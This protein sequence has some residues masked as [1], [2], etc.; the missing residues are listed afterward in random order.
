MQLKIGLLTTQQTNIGDDLIRRGLI[1]V[2]DNCNNGNEYFPVN[3]HWPMHAYPS[4]HPL[5]I[6]SRLSPLPKSLA[7]KLHRLAY[8]RFSPSSSVFASCD[9]ILQCGTPVYHRNCHNDEWADPIWRHIFVPLSER[10]PIINLAAGACFP[11]ADQPES[12]SGAPSESYV[13]TITEC[14]NVTTVRDQLA[15][16]LVGS[17]TKSAP[18]VVPC[19]AFLHDYGNDNRESQGTV[20]INYMPSAGHFNWGKVVDSEAYEKNFV[21]FVNSIA[22]SHKVIM[23]CH[24]ERERTHAERLWPQFDVALPKTA[25]EYGGAIE[26]CVAGVCNRMHAAVALAGSGIPAIA[27]CTDTRLLMVKE[28]GLPIFYGGDLDLNEVRE[29]LESLIANFQDHR[30]RLLALRKD[31]FDRY[32]KIVTGELEKLR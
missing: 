3:K 7:L 1:N 23:L 27:I 22:E 18:E 2:F 13:R 10:M 24:D 17:V 28:L 8:R 31:T 19:S 26:G 29:S 4:G 9:L 14:C 5:R 12:L 15:S 6:F 25:A 11:W 21:D 32:S 16:K 20:A 30:E